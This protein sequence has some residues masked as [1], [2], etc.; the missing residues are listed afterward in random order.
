MIVVD[1]SSR[2]PGRIVDEVKTVA[3]LKRGTSQRSTEK[4]GNV[5]LTFIFRP[6]RKGLS[7]SDRERNFDD[8]CLHLMIMA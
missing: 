7:Y 8:E 1:S 5:C 2:K 4:F 6:V 3:D